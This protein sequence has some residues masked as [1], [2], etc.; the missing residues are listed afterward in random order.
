LFLVALAALAQTFRSGDVIEYKARG[1]YPPQWE[2]GVFVRDLPGGKQAIIREK[3][4]QF[5]PEGFEIAYALDDIRVPGAAPPPAK[6]AVAMP[7]PDGP[8]VGKEELIAFARQT[9]GP[10]PWNNP[11]RESAL[12]AIRDLV[13]RRGA[14]FARDDDFRARMDAQGTMSVHIGYA[15]D[16]NFGPPP[17]ADAYFGTW[18]L[19]AANRG[20][21]SVSSDGR[22]VTTTDSQAESG[23]LTID[24]GGT[25]TWETLRGDPPAK[26]LRGRWRVVA[27]G[28]ANAWEGGPALWLEKAKQGY[29]CMVRMDRQPGW[30]GWIQ[31]GMGA[32]RTPVEYGRK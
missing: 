2:R 10:N 30:P 1:T 9:M 27:A 7:S 13:T 14:A 5:N 16:A 4:N 24:P 21:R 11:Q 32:A 26:W 29:D 15:V 19:R 20:S 25:Y 8:P 23:R 17:R 18:L 31:V 3:P 6:V 28:E 12:A 22:T